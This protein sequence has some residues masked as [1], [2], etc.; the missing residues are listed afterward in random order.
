M[1]LLFFVYNTVRLTSPPAD[2]PAKSMKLSADSE[3]F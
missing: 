2:V 1:Y 3:V